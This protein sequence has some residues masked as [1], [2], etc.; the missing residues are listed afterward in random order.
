M[1]GVNGTDIAFDSLLGAWV[2]ESDLA[3]RWEIIFPEGEVT[4][5]GF[6][7]VESDD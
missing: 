1:V 2:A 6:V 3:R 5:F 4:M 7:L